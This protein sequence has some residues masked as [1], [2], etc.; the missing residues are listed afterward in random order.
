M[1]PSNTAIYKRPL[2]EEMAGY[3]E[4]MQGKTVTR[5]KTSEN[6]GH[7]T[8]SQ[9]KGALP[10]LLSLGKAKDDSQWGLQSWSEVK[11]ASRSSRGPRIHFSETMWMLTTVCSSRPRGSDALF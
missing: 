3:A 2:L 10:P 1:S 4:K 8:R 7:M 11:N 6:M 5:R 9:P